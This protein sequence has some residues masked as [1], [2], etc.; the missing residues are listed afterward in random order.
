LAALR[1]QLVT[2]MLVWLHCPRSLPEYRNGHGMHLIQ[3]GDATDCC[4]DE[5]GMAG[6]LGIRTHLI[7]AGLT[8]LLQPSGRSVFGALKAEYRAINSMDMP[9][10]ATSG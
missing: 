7:P 10:R 3:D 9:Q 4:E 6:E 1:A 5:M 2:A 8:D